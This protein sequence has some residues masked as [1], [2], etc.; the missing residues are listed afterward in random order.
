MKRADKS[1]Q[2]TLTDSSDPL[3]IELNILL[4]HLPNLTDVNVAELKLISKPQRKMFSDIKLEV[5]PPE[6]QP[7]KLVVP[8]YI[9]FGEITACKVSITDLRGDESEPPT[10]FL[11]I[12]DFTQNPPSMHQHHTKGCIHF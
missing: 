4:K 8:E 9:N 10:D 11:L 1:K 7:A 12:G 3:E 6:D 5:H 2:T